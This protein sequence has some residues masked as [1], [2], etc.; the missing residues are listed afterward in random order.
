MLYW[1]F[2]TS[3]PECTTIEFSLLNELEGFLS[4]F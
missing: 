4:T 2:I 3:M 1:E